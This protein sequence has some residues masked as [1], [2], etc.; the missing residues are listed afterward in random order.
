MNKPFSPAM[1][2]SLAKSAEFASAAPERTPRTL[3]LEGIDKQIELFKKPSADGRR[4][5]T[6]GQ[7]EVAISLRVANKPLKLIGDDVKVVVPLEHF[8]AAM[9]HFKAEAEQ[10]VFDPQLD[11]LGQM[12][13][14]RRTKLR[15]VRAS[16]KTPQNA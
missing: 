8:E 14:A 9:Q 13:D 4:W 6:M 16:K 11:G 12:M 3:L 2:V 5:F 15:E 10:G 7:K 1:I